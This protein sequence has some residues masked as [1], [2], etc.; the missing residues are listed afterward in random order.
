MENKY[1]NKVKILLFVLLFL[2]FLS[3]LACGIILR[4][5]LDLHFPKIGHAPFGF[6]MAQ[7]GSIICFIMIL[8]L[9]NYFMN[10]LDM[11]YKS[12]IKD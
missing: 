8:L 6:W 4:E 10:K 9:Y 7:Q 5:W 3:S 12:G 11:K 1:H 2:W